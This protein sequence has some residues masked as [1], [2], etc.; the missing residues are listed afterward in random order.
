L[1]IPTQEWCSLEI[2]LVADQVGLPAPVVQEEEV[3]RV[4]V[5]GVPAVAE[6]PLVEQALVV[7]VQV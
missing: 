4:V 5:L 6:V 3:V 1:L 7:Q 2:Y